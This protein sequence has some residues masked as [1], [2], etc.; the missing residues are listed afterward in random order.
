M[1]KN[2]TILLQEEWFWHQMIDHFYQPFHTS[3]NTALEVAGRKSGE[4]SV[5]NH[6]ESGKPIIVKIGRYG[7]MAQNW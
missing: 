7:P 3:I 4:R 2:L 6:P 1:R 5:G